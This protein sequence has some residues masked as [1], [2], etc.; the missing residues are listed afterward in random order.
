VEKLAAVE[1]PVAVEDPAKAGTAPQEPSDPGA[2]R[3][4]G[5]VITPALETAPSTPPHVVP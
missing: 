5:E 2:A 3:T 4:N 1:D